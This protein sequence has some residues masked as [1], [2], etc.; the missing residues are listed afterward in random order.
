MI[1]RLWTRFILRYVRQ[2]LFRTLLTVLGIA[3]GVGILLAI[4]L[5]NHTALAQFQ[6]SLNRVSGATTMEIHSPLGVLD[7]RLLEGIAPVIESL[8]IDT[9]GP[10]LEETVLLQKTQQPATLLSVDL[11]QS[12]D[13]SEDSDHFQWVNGQEPVD[14]LSLF[15]PEQAAVGEN[16]AKQ[17]HVKRGDWLRILVHDQWKRFQVAGVLSDSG[18][19]GAYDGQLILMD[20]GNAQQLLELTGQLTRVDLTVADARWEKT[21]TRLRQHLPSDVLV[22]RPQ[23]RSE[24]VASMLRSFQYNLVALSFIALLVSMFLIYNT[25]SVSVVRRRPEIGILRALGLTRWQVGGLFALEALLMGLL[26]AS[27]GIC[28]GI[29]L[30]RG[31]VQAMSTTV[32]TLYLGQPLAHVVLD[33]T[34]IIKL[35]LLGVV[36]TVGAAIFP[37][38]ES[39]WVSPAEATRRGSADN[40]LEQWLPRL[41]YLGVALFGLAGWACVQPP[42][43]DFPLF[44]HLASFCSVLAA[45]CWIPSCLLWLT[46]PLRHGFGLIFGNMGRL[47]VSTLLGSLGRTSVAVASL[48]VAIAMTVSLAVMIGSFRYTVIGWVNQSFKADLW[49][50]PASRTL[51]RNGLM[52]PEVVQVIAK[53]PG[54][55]LVDYFYETPMEIQEKPSNLATGDFK[56]FK[57][58]GNLRFVDGESMQSVMARVL[59]NPHSAL[60]TETF[61]VKQ[62]VKKNDVISIPT[63]TGPLSLTIQGIY[64][65]YASERGHLVIDRPL[66]EKRFRSHAISGL[67][68]YISEGFS[69][70]DV[71]KT[72]LARLAVAHQARVLLTM[73]TNRELRDEVL[74]VFDNTFAITYA[75]HAISI[76]VALLG[77]MNT[78]FTLVIE[79]RREFGILKY[80]G[81]KAQQLKKIVLIQATLLGLLGNISGGLMGIVIAVL[82]IA[83]INKQSFGWSIQ[84]DLPVV[85]LIQTALLIKLTALIAA[86]VPAQMASRT[87]APSSL[88]LE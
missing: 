21:A 6:D 66:F 60:V 15:R 71:K 57:Q 87:M 81:A 38:L 76:A 22:S 59:S 28:F 18:L 86:I 56:I 75:L 83:V 12:R 49:I 41:R 40:H 10:V 77:V 4:N 36:L 2:N 5:A 62:H 35:W 65:D 54:V 53:T 42:V 47:A 23:R 82:L 34:L 43:G 45:A 50:E 8:N 69:P 19:G 9:W 61:A 44:G 31:A 17:A 39:M 30:A 24:Q 26:G 67:A 13:N 1:A 84:W 46:V 78:L 68:V 27:L 73:R 20:V 70:S 85:F 88:R 25:M 64:Y 74:R 63:P 48:M 51:T 80:I 33:T 37:V 3:L 11:T 29:L 72:I 55:A 58:R 14:F 79:A 52:R 16:L 7:E 32:Q